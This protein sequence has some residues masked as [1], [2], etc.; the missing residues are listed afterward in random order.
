MVAA[1]TPINRIPTNIIFG[2]LGAGKTTAV[3]D[4]L[5][6]K[7]RNERWA[8]LVNEFGEIGIDGKIIAQTGVALKEIPGGCL[9]C[10]AG[11]PFQVGLTELVR[12]A[13]PDRLLIEP[14]G[15][16][17]PKEIVST[18]QNSTNQE[19]ITLQSTITLVD[20]RK[21]KDERYLNHEHFMGQVELADV[22]LANKADVCTQE[23]LDTFWRFAELYVGTKLQTAVTEHGRIALDW[24]NKGAGDYIAKGVHDPTLTDSHYHSHHHKKG[25]AEDPNTHSWTFAASQRFDYNKLMLW[26][27][28]FTSMRLKAVVNTNQGNFIINQSDSDPIT[29]TQITEVMENIIEVIG[30]RFDAKCDDKN[31]CVDSANIAEG[32]FSQKDIGKSLTKCLIID[33][34]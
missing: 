7:P 27:R 25:H 6:R 18:L 3:L 14:T 26:V 20:P 19:F 23:D 34:L 16:G 5:A 15:L 28:S 22:L 9:C 29:V 13:N 30:W 17:H 24:L 11:V 4:L 33:N 2:F 8:V 21:L 31:D 1:S 12:K 32:G 10:A